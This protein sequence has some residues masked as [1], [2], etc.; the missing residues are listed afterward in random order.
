MFGYPVISFEDAENANWEVHLYQWLIRNLKRR[1]SFF[2]PIFSEELG[3]T[4][5]Y[6]TLVFC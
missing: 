1:Y 4:L 2:S 3:L 5:H 6:I